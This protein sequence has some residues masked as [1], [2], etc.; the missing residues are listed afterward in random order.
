MK[1]YLSFSI[2][3]LVLSCSLQA[4]AQNTLPTNESS[5]VCRN[6]QQDIADVYENGAL[7]KCYFQHDP[8]LIAYEKYR[9]LQTQDDKAFL[10][11]ALVLNENKEVKCPNDSCISINYHWDGNDK[12]NI[13]QQFAGGETHL[14]LIQDKKG[15]SIE[16]RHFS[17]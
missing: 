1:K 15:T 7:T 8:L 9:N 5:Q 2:T 12:L 10:V 4:I 16:V 6:E 11:E 14:K 13:E 3:A 17:D